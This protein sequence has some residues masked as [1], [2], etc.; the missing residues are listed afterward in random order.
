MCG[1]FQ[2]W[3]KKSNNYHDLSDRAWT[4]SPSFLLIS[5]FEMSSSES[6]KYINLIGGDGKQWMI[7]W[8]CI[9]G[10]IAVGGE[11]KKIEKKFVYTYIF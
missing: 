8:W 10:D 1:A 3:S 5:C 7:R 4:T 2:K 9:I 6:Q 11:W